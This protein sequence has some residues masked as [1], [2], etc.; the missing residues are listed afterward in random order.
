[1]PDKIF[2]F[3][4]YKHS[5]FMGNNI[6]KAINPDD[7]IGKWL[8]ADDYGSNGFGCENAYQLLN[9]DGTMIYGNHDI[10][11]DN[12]C[13]LMETPGTW[14]LNGKIL[15]IILKESDG[16]GSFEQLF[17]IRYLDK[18]TLDIVTYT[19]DRDRRVAF[20]LTKAQ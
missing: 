14:S 1:M 15:S 13:V 17:S 10:V 7:L 3:L 6:L 4:L 11:G 16:N 20:V 18:T 12:P 2:V 5:N 9:A 19:N 8:F